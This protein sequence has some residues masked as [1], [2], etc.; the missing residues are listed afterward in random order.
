MIIGVDFDNTIVSYHT[1]FHRV[2]V[3]QGVISADF[4][5]IKDEVRN[6]LRQSGREAE[7]T[8]MQ[9][10]VYGGRMA[11]AEPFLGALAFFRRCRERGTPVYIISHKT[12]QPFIGPP[13]ELHQA[14]WDWLAANAF[15]DA[16]GAGLPV[17]HVFFELTK[18]E[19]C[20]RIA[21]LGC[22]HFIDDLPEFLT[23]A[24]FPTGVQKIW[25]APHQP[26]AVPPE[27]T[28]VLSWA[29]VETMLF[30]S[31]TVLP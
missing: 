26:E 8:A 27:L 14:A 21:A 31:E 17:D 13:V 25:F 15:L 28:P 23:D 18:A 7:W 9:G 1:L 4:P 11:E 5:P 6:Y 16:A 24:Q 29:A 22:T 12:R 20:Q 10:Q 2:A 3:E 30:N 19:K